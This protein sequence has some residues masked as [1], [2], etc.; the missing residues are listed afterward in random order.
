MIGAFVTAG[1]WLWAGL[2]FGEE[3]A[4]ARKRYPLM[5]KQH[6]VVKDRFGC[7]STT[8]SS[9]EKTTLMDPD[10]DVV[11]EQIYSPNK[12]FFAFTDL[13]RDTTVV[14]EEILRGNIGKKEERWETAGCRELLAVS[15][16]GECLVTGYRGMD[17]LPL[18]RNED[19]VM[20]SFFRLGECV[21]QVRL[22]ELVPDSS[23]LLRSA[24]GCSWGAYRGLN[25]AGHYVVETAGGE[26]VAFDPKSGERVT[27]PSAE[28]GLSAGWKAFRETMRCYEFQYPGE[29]ALDA[30]LYGDGT[31]D[32]SITL[33]RER[34]QGSVYGWVSRIADA[35]QET[36]EPGK[37]SFEDFV[38]YEIRLTHEADGPDGSTSVAGVAEKRAFTNPNG[39]EVLEI[40]PQEVSEHYS[41]EGGRA[42]VEKRTMGPFY[43]VRLSEQGAPYRA[44]IF[45]SGREGVASPRDRE[46]LRKIVDTVRALR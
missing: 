28:A 3:A 43:A 25:D 32:G 40:Y 42:K 20:L 33:K 44:L 15:D 16:D 11:A 17:L 14:Y 13:V 22:K 1:S 12:R 9:R 35:P 4:P 34:P 23:A 37:M 21:K 10:G 26:E 8:V 29:Y 27:F 30:G 2:G 5:S 41:E 18:G 39:L 36:V 19:V 45:E 24:Y 38:L 46:T 31:P 7:Y 6:L